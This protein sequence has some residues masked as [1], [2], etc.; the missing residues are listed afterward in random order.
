MI[1]FLKDR[2]TE[3]LRSGMYTQCYNSLRVG[4]AHDVFGVLMD[5]ID[6][7]P[8]EPE[9]SGPDYRYGQELG[10]PSASWL[11]D[12]K[13]PLG[14]ARQLAIRNDVS[15]WDFSKLADLV[16]KIVPENT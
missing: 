4:V 2:W 7:S 1:K 16:D 12:M 13:I 8:W 5:T 15:K 9:G 11:V 3:A 14:V 10:F 6:P